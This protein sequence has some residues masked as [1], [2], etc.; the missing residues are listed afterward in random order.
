MLGRAIRAPARRW[1]FAASASAALTED[2]RPA[3]AP[4]VGDTPGS[5]SRTAGFWALALLPFLLLL[6]LNWGPGPPADAT[7]AYHYMLHG[8]A[9]AEGSGYSNTGYIFTTL[10]PWIGPRVQPPGVAIFLYPAFKFFGA[11][12]L[13]MRLMVAA[14][15]IAFLLL[16]GLYFARL[17]GLY[18]G[19]SVTLLVGLIPSIA[20]FASNTYSDLVSAASM[21][22]V[23]Y[24]MDSERPFDAR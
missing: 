13:L 7:D 3:V 9:L 10:N 6:V 12:V 22:A 17:E 2:R 20:A 15:T 11:N 18:M 23:V 21:W 8:R 16:C 1:T 5:G 4:P 19:L 14:C 24:V